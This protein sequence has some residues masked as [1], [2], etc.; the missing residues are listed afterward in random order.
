V[1]GRRGT[2][3]AATFAV[4]LVVLAA[5]LTPLAVVSAGRTRSIGDTDRYVAT[6]RRS[7][8]DLGTCRTPS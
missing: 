3:R 2:A 1:R 4:V 5:L 7:P 8:S 6:M